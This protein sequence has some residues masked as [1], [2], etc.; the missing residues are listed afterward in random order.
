MKASRVNSLRGI[1]VLALLFGATRAS[2]QAQQ[3]E[4]VRSAPTPGQ[5]PP[6]PGSANVVTVRVVTD[7][8]NV[9]PA[10]SGGL[11]VQSGKPLNRS[12]V[13]DSLR[14]LFRTGDY[15]DVRAVETPVSG[16]VEIDFVVREQLFFNRVVIEG[17]TAP[18]SDASA[19]AAMQFSLGQAYRKDLVE[20]GLARLRDVL[21]EEGLYASEVSAEMQTHPESRQMDIV[22]HVEPGPRAPGGRV[23]TQ[24]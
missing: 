19:A 14:V 23:V 13:A 16:G 17:L 15:A 18:P 4:Q 24:N 6:A 10:P 1:V 22:V 2:V 11:A 21:H 3:L 12:Q 7:P 20:E 9:L 5:A 8:G